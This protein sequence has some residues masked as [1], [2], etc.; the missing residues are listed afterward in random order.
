MMGMLVE[1]GRHHFEP[2][3][4]KEIL[5]SKNPCDSKYIL[6]GCGLYLFKVEY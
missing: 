2:H 1:I 5:E 4:I 6:D 3:S